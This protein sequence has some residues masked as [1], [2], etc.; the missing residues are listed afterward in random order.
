MR[1]AAAVAT[2]AFASM[3][4]AAGAS[5]STK[6]GQLFQPSAAVSATMFQTGVQDGTG[7]SVPSDGVVTSWSFLP[8]SAGA[9]L[10]LKA[11]RKNDDGTYTVIGES[12]NQTVTGAT[13]TFPARIP[14][15]AG[16]IIG[17]AG[18]QGNNVVYFGPQN[19]NDTVI[20]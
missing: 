4:M 11:A 15:R 12:D 1:A 9:T 8:D 2:V 7:Y 13:G 19:Q 10:K 3:L 17:T 20:V 5:A 16:D 18:T 6:I 14:V